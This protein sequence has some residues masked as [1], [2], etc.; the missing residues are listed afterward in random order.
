MGGWGRRGQGRG[1]RVPELCPAAQDEESHPCGA[2]SS[3]TLRGLLTHLPFLAPHRVGA[4]LS[5]LTLPRPG[6]LMARSLSGALS[7]PGRTWAR[8][9]CQMGWA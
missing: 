3:T 5:L 8:S 1:K 2:R 4:R 9:L 6:T 7:H